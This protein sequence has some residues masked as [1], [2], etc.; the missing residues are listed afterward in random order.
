M[1]NYFVY[2]NVPSSQFGCEVSDVSSWNS[3]FPAFD[4][5][6][7]PGVLGDLVHYKD[8]Y[9]NINITYR[10]M[11]KDGNFESGYDALRA[12][13]LKE[14]GYH[15]LW[16][17]YHKNEYRY[18]VIASQLQPTR[19]GYPMTNGVVDVTFY[20]KPQRYYSD[21][22]SNYGNYG[23]DKDSSF[24]Q[25]IG[26]VYRDL[27]LTNPTGRAARPLIYFENGY[28]K[29]VPNTNIGV[30]SN[31]S[32]GVTYDVRNAPITPAVLETGFIDCELGVIRSVK[33]VS[34]W[35]PNG[36]TTKLYPDRIH[37]ESTK[38]LVWN[39]HLDLLTL[40]GDG[41]SQRVHLAV[42]G[43]GFVR[44]RWWTI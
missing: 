43:T 6:Q 21:P 10:C 39:T 15:K 32:G 13:L 7:V 36:S 3:S 33:E 35:G 30:T 11:W 17:T 2:N 38:K 12:H 29:A 41:M 1:M 28:M 18:G 9:T 42:M 37:V 40:Y 25:P 24:I 8:T 14:P 16:D 27:I 31:A 34:L 23:L 19:L 26:D 4:T 44:P 22:D 20:C 5:A